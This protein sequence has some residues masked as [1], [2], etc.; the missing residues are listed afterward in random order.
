MSENELPR[1]DVARGEAPTSTTA[2][3]E[4]AIALV[5]QT[6]KQRDVA[7][8]ARRLRVFAL[9]MVSLAVFAFATCIFTGSMLTMWASEEIVVRDMSP[10]TVVYVEENHGLVLAGHVMAG[11]F[12]VVA[13]LA[14]AGLHVRFRRLFQQLDVD[15]KARKRVFSGW[16]VVPLAL[17]L[18][19]ALGTAAVIGYAL[20]DKPPTTER[21]EH[22][23]EQAEEEPPTVVHEGDEPWERDRHM[24]QPGQID[25]Q[26]SPVPPHVQGA[27]EREAWMLHTFWLP[28]FIGLA[29]I[30]LLPAVYTLQRSRDALKSLDNAGEADAKKRSRKKG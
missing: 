12:T 28:L 30:V 1:D 29:L 24:P 26:P 15:E 4:A 13:L 25:V 22:R 16:V 20:P 18:S 6:S 10:P 14:Y 27:Q 17:M 23:L 9:V 11:F 21:L 2:A 3:A 5:Q 7:R 19:G 8:P